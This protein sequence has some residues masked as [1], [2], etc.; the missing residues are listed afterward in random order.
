[1][2]MV[3]TGTTVVDADTVG[4]DVDV[5]L[6]RAKVQVEVK[7]LEVDGLADQLAQ[8]ATDVEEGLPLELVLAGPAGV[9]GPVAK[10][11]QVLL[12]Q[13]PNMDQPVGVEKVEDEVRLEVELVDTEVVTPS[14]GVELEVPLQALPQAQDTELVLELEAV[15]VLLVGDEVEMPLTGVELDVGQ[16]VGLA[17]E[18][19]EVVQVELVDEVVLEVGLEVVVLDVVQVELVDDVVLEVGLEVGLEVV[20]VEVVVLVVVLELVVEVVLD[21]V[22]E[23]VVGRPQELP[24]RRGLMTCA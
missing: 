17:V 8:V 23:P 22:V 13:V 20:L 21:V 24:V 16:L 4:T 18:E 9:P 6:G 11:L 3:M 5:E 1:M 15:E 10:P 19:Y 7:V 12:V 2:V 14:T